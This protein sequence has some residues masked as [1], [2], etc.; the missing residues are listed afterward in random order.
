[1]E[2]KLEIYK[3]YQ[4]ITLGGG[5]LVNVLVK[6]TIDIDFVK[7]YIIESNDIYDISGF[8]REDIEEQVGEFIDELVEYMQDRL[9][10]ADPDYINTVNIKWIC[11]DI[12]ESFPMIS[13][14]ITKIPDI[15]YTK[16][17]EEPDISE[18]E[19]KISAIR[20]KIELEA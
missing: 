5:Y 10:T 2:T 11:H 7:N 17:P 8:V 9:L 15:S 20:E 6:F 13:C 12:K 4:K 18:F 1:M 19:G 3:K 14:E 16:V